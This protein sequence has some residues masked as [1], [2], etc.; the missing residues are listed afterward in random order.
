MEASR[1]PKYAIYTCFYVQS[2][3]PMALLEASRN[4]F[5]GPI[6]AVCECFCVQ[7]QSLTRF[8][9][10]E[11][12]KGSCKPSRTPKYTVYTRFYVPSEAPGSRFRG[13]KE[14]FKR[15]K[16]CSLCVLLRATSWLDMFLRK[17][18][19]DGILAPSRSPKYGVYTCF[20]MQSE[21]P[22]ALLEASSNHPRGPRY[23][24]YVCFCV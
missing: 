8:C 16:I 10:N 7:Q 18:G 1:S 3:A 9:T 11:G 5:R 6:Y 2:E 21:A 4:H 22:M 12:P 14:P 20:D 19:L 13:A 15:S 24:I 23:A 17:S